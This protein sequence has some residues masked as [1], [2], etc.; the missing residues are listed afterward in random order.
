VT[1]GRVSTDGVEVLSGLQKGDVIVAAGLSQL[2]A[3]MKVKPLRW[4]RGV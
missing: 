3:G 2:S 1:L 4:Q